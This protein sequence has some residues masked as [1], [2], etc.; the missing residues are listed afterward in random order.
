[1]M[2][3]VFFH[4]WR[5]S[6]PNE[7]NPAVIF[8]IIAII[9][10]IIIA[11]YDESCTYFNTWHY[12]SLLSL[13][14]VLVVEVVVSPAKLTQW[15]VELLDVDRPPHPWRWGCG[16]VR[17]PGGRRWWKRHSHRGWRDSER[18]RVKS[19]WVEVTSSLIIRWSWDTSSCCTCTVSSLTSSRSTCRG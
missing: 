17:T 11:V 18:W 3:A 5:I 13:V 19:R 10:K 2:H 14:A 4:Y 9:I 12:I 8:F 6:Y 15:W 16:K 1:M 7:I